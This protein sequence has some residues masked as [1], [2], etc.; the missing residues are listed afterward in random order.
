MLFVEMGGFEPPC[1][2]FSF[3]LHQLCIFIQQVLT[4]VKIIQW[5]V[6]LIRLNQTLVYV[7]TNDLKLIGIRG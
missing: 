1:S 6:K 4:H 5:I 3:N 2:Q 7:H